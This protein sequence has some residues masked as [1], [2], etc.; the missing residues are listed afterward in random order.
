M[1]HKLFYISSFD[2][3][4]MLDFWYKIISLIQDDTNFVP[5]QRKYSKLTETIK[6]A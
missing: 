5:G 3:D 4:G 1:V 6:F 2:T